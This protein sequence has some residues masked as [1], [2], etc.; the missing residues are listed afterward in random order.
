MSA[1]DSEPD[2]EPD[3]DPDPELESE[4]ESESESAPD[5]STTLTDLPPSAKL[6]YKVLEY[7]GSLTQE[8]LAAE[9]RLCSRTVRYALGKLENAEHVDSRVSLQD[10]RQ[11]K[12]RIAE[13]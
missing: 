10:A 9:S 8:E 4:A 7:E 2:A 1:T 13:Q 11:S 6:V 3:R 5:P 12:Y